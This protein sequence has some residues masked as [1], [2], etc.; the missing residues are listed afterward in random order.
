MECTI[1]P[2]PEPPAAEPIAE[3]VPGTGM[4]E[5]DGVMCRFE[6]SKGGSFTL[7]N[8]KSGKT[9]IA[10]PG[11]DAYFTVIP[12]SDTGLSVIIPETREY[13]LNLRRRQNENRLLLGNA[14]DDNGHIC[15]WDNGK[16]FNDPS[17][18]FVHDLSTIFDC[19]FDIELIGLSGSQVK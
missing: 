4:Y 10:I 13:L 3:Y 5:M 1:Q 14:Y 15:V 11:A 7:I 12:V 8:S 16:Q 18:F 9:V 17:D 6:K 2:T 19:E